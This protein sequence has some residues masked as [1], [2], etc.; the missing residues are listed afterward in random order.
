[1][2]PSL[3]NLPIGGKR[4]ASEALELFALSDKQPTPQLL[5]IKAARDA[6]REGEGVNYAELLKDSFDVLAAVV[7]YA[8]GFF[9]FI[10]SL[11]RSKLD[12]TAL[13]K[14]S[15]ERSGIPWT[16]ELRKFLQD[17]LD[18]QYDQIWNTHLGYEEAHV[19]I[20][21]LFLFWNSNASDPSKLSS[22]LEAYMTV[23]GNNAERRALVQNL[24]KYRYDVTPDYLSRRLLNAAVDGRLPELDIPLRKRLAAHVDGLLGDA[25]GMFGVTLDAPMTLF[26]ADDRGDSLN[27]IVDINATLEELS[28]T[29]VSTSVNQSIRHLFCGSVNEG[30][31]R[32]VIYKFLVAAG[33]RILP[34]TS[35]HPFLKGPLIDEMFTPY[36]NEKEILLP[37]GVTYR[38]DS[39]TEPV[40]DTLRNG[41][42]TVTYSVFVQ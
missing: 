31:S 21:A 17:Q 38:L 4:K 28:G 33:T 41:R 22:A 26:R 35:D 12:A 1:M 40:Y 37:K 18:R 13:Y 32:C 42:L 25:F 29:V 9:G 20:A 14:D 15:T 3:V 27:T 7:L 36:S 8:K 24:I 30:D 5:Q 23:P 19:W 34:I 11:N 16:K 2:Y 39:S 6:K 10:L